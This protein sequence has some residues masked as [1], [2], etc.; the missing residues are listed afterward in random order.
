VLVLVLR[1]RVRCEL[2][3]PPCPPSETARV[4]AV[5]APP[6]LA[7]SA[8]PDLS[9]LPDLHIAGFLRLAWVRDGTYRDPS[10]WLRRFYSV[11]RIESLSPHSAAPQLRA[12]VPTAGVITAGVT[13]EGSISLHVYHSST[14]VPSAQPRRVGR[15]STS[16]PDLRTEISVDAGTQV[17]PTVAQRSSRTWT[18]GSW[19][20][21]K[22]KKKQESCR[23]GWPLADDRTANLGPSLH[24]CIHHL[25]ICRSGRC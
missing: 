2:S 5:Q 11:L 10:S 24:V 23:R 19:S 22:R 14:N 15:L 21:S 8:R 9:V 1:A 18:D 25:R 3:L 4:K 6:L 16:A 12:D 20:E 7:V 17:E 13:Y